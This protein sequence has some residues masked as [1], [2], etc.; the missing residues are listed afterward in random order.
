MATATVEE[1]TVDGVSY[2]LHMLQGYTNPRYQGR[3]HIRDADSS[4]VVSNTFFLDMEQAR[5]KYAETLR[6]LGV[7]VSYMVP[8]S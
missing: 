8:T 3:I 2:E 1:H 4:N 5:V 6:V 7:A